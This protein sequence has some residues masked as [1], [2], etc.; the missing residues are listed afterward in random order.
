MELEFPS[1]KGDFK[2]FIKKQ[3]EEINSEREFIR[4]K[5]DVWLERIR[6]ELNST[7]EIKQKTK[8]LIDLGKFI[9]CF[10]RKIEI[11]DALCESPDFIVSIGNKKIGIEL[12]DIVIRQDEKQREGL[13]K[14]IFSQLEIEL[15]KEPNKYNGIYR[16]DFVEKIKFDSNDQAT[17]RTELLDLIKNSRDSG[18]I[19]KDVRK[20]PHTGV[21]IYHSK[22]SIVGSLGR[23][24]IDKTIKKKELKIPKYSS[25]RFD[26]IWLLTVA[27]GAQASDDYSFIED[28]VLRV[29][30]DTSFNRIFLLNFFASEIFELLTNNI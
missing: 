17:I 5:I 12:A 22:A 13:L 2:S 8:E 4:S 16:V 21:S 23:T 26:E 28:S 20:S 30:F 6:S 25:E 19:V 3:T 18:T 14:K 29:P 15:K 10:D 7:N 27:G 24:V 9:S 1:N 11:S